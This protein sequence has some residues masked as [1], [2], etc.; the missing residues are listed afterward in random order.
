MTRDTPLLDPSDLELFRFADDPQ[1][2]LEIQKGTLPKE[3]GP[4]TPDFATSSA[5]T[6]SIAP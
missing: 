6:T 2:A 1:T 4:A 5:S 3:M